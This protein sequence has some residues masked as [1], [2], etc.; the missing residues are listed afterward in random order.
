MDLFLCLQFPRSDAKSHSQTHIES[1]LN[2]ALRGLE[3]TQNQV[4]ELITVVKEQ[5]QQIE[6]QS[7]QIEGQ[8]QKIDQMISKDK[9][10]TQQIER[11]S[12]QIERQSQQIERLISKDK[13][14]LEKMERLM[15]T[16]EDQ[17]QQIK[18]SMSKD[19]EQ[20]EKMERSISTVQGQPPQKG[21]RESVQ[22]Q[23]PQKELREPINQI[24]PTPFEWEI[25]NIIDFFKKATFRSQ[26]LVSKPFNLFER[27]YK[28]LLQIKSRSRRFSNE[29]RVYI[30]VVPGEFDEL[31]SWPCK[32]KVRV[33]WADQDP[34]IEKCKSNVIDFEKCREP[35]SRPLDD[36]HHA[37]RLVLDFTVGYY[38]V[39]DTILIRVNRE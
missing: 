23:P 16:V 15:S 9:E 7:Q 39:K 10:Q 30:K 2:L 20:S 31:L 37:Y 24:L 36:D 29:L 26:F 28:Y 6:R 19:E 18:R 33:T 1:H 27:G 22:G 5:S 8:S 34:R 13:E 32:E 21:R 12:Q 11:Q 3:A 38:L 4:H 17:S 35:C 25:P 14:Q